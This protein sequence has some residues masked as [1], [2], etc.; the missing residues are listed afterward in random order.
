M[1]NPLLF[2][3]LCFIYI[4]IYV[5]AGLKQL[6]TT[7]LVTLI[8][9]GIRS[10]CCHAGFQLITRHNCQGENAVRLLKVA[11]I[12]TG[13]LFL[14]GLALVGNWKIFISV[15]WKAS[16]AV[17]EQWLWAKLFRAPTVNNP[18]RRLTSVTTACSSNHSQTE[19]PIQF[20]SFKA[21]SYE[22]Q[23]SI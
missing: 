23:I 12:V 13:G 20:S 19:M 7:V 17:I 8:G 5:L 14:Q 15:P 4:I 3:Q 18:F 2:R 16:T 11:Y 1:L 9:A 21:L 10:C 6:I 22:M